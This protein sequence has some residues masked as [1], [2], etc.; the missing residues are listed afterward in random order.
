VHK[1]L[2]NNKLAKERIKSNY[3]KQSKKNLQMKNLKIEFTD[4]EI[5]SWGGMV[6][7]GKMLEKMSIDEELK[8]INLPTQG[9]NRG[10]SPL[11]LIKTFWIS[12]WS[13][14][15]KFE[16]LEV[17]RQDKVI[18]EIFGWKR[19]PGHRAFQRYFNKFNQGI[20]QEVFGKLYEWFFDNLKFDNYTLDIDS[21]I[22]PRYGNQQGS[23]KGYNP[24]KPGRNSHHPLIAFISDIKM[25]ANFWLRA[26][27]SYTANN[28]KGFLC[29]TLE[30]LKSKK[31]GLIRL[32]SGFYGKEI[33][34]YLEEKTINYIVAARL[35]TPIKRKLAYQETWL[36]LD[37]G[38]EIAEVEYQSL[39]WKK[40]RRM[41]MVRQEINK[42]PKAVGKQFRIFE[43]EEIYKNYRYSAFITNMDLP[44]K[45]I[46]DL[47]RNR[48]NAENRIKELKYDFGADSFNVRNFWATEAAL[49]FVMIG[50]NIM[51][52]FKQ[53]ILQS[54]KEHQ[55]S[56]LRY[57]VFA[58]G[59]YLVK[60]GNQKILKL[61]LAMKR[62]KWFLG[63]WNST[64]FIRFPFV[65]N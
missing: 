32:D 30:K 5:T 65:V 11:Q 27:N 60:N 42:R 64:D 53:M 56:T 54:P 46:Y 39:E 29:D 19:M 34:N 24:K 61:S 48:A 17:T 20:N 35:Y 15:N 12:L 44:A 43:N 58:I 16:H 41:I 8:K 55:L 25:V 52:L 36:K 63:L 9:S 45:V 51:S 38:I 6:L 31:I 10:Y 22:M 13:G 40:P 23:K 1:L 28:F 59:S 57:R 62:R 7:L 3:T 14:A 4:K 33:F 26:G 21:T 37:E 47:Y 50:Y 2:K 18:A 49:N